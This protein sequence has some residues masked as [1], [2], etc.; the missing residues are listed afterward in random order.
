MAGRDQSPGLG[1]RNTPQVRGTTLTQVYTRDTNVHAHYRYTHV[2]IHRRAVRTCPH[3]RVMHTRVHLKS[4][5]HVF[6]HIHM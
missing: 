2:H 3:Q 6:L 4:L 5:P 1:K